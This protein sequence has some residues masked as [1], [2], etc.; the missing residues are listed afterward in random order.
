MSLFI[1]MRSGQEEIGSDS[2]IKFFYG[3]FSVSAERKGCHACRLCFDK[4]AKAL[5]I[6]CGG[7]EMMNGNTKS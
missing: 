2:V 6:R 5:L 4:G 1:F 3:K 7:D